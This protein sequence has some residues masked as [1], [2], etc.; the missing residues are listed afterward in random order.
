M[1]DFLGSIF[2][3]FG[4][5][6][7]FKFIY[8][9]E[10][11]MVDIDRHVFP[12]KKYRMLYEKVINLGARHKD[13]I[14]PRPAEEKDLLLVHTPKYVQKVTTGTLSSIELQ[15]LEMPF[16]PEVVRFFKLMTGGTIRTV[17]EALKDGLAVHLGGGF[18]HAFP[19]HGE[20]FCLF[21]DVAVAVEKMKREGRLN[22]AMIVDGDLHQGNGTAFIF[23]KKDYVF[24]FS[25]HQMDIHPAEKPPD[26]LDVELWSGDDDEAYLAGLSPHFPRIY[27][28]FKP[29]LVVYVAGADPYRGDMLSGLDIS[30]EA[31]RK[32][33]RIIIGQAYQLKIPI[34]IVLGGGYAAEIEETVEIHLNTIREALRAFRRRAQTR[35]TS[36]I[37][38]K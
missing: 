36:L 25:I 38:S 5:R 35:F 15:A 30:A 18:H 17:E 9:N 24:T 23:S 21:N 22:R 8:S 2:S 19:D 12:V 13:F 4:P 6:I 28:E 37:Q 32:R 11:W 16:S 7:P 34:A 3:L 31:L 33:D 20:G 10:Y 14:E 1:A 29:D 27:Q 26:N